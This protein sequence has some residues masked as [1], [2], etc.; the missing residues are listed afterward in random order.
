MANRP[1]PLCVGQY[2]DLVGT[3]GDTQTS[4]TIN[5]VQFVDQSEE[6]AG[7]GG[8][9]SRFQRRMGEMLN[10]ECRML[11]ERRPDGS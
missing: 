4:V 1:V 6:P 2:L 11:N 10:D 5:C 7:S 9:K 8:P 3:A